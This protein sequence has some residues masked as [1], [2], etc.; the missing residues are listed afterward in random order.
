MLDGKKQ[1]SAVC[2]P[3]LSEPDY[4]GCQPADLPYW[5]GGG[6]VHPGGQ[7]LAMR[8]PSQ[9]QDADGQVARGTSSKSE[10]LSPIS[11]WRPVSS[12]GLA[13][14]ARCRP[15]LLVRHPGQARLDRMTAIFTP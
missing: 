6:L 8:P 15:A 12:A 7:V 1:V 5:K 14:A 9:P 3:A 4:R 11:R 2:F 13:R 10:T